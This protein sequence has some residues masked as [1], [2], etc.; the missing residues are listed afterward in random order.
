[1]NYLFFRQ[2]TG[3]IYVEEKAAPPSDGELELPL[4]LK[5]VTADQDGQRLICEA[6][7]SYPPEQ[8]TVRQHTEISV[9]CESF[10]SRIMDNLVDHA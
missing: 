7:T 1:M 3:K 10:N 2:A 6:T 9:Y 8:S 4:T 5:N